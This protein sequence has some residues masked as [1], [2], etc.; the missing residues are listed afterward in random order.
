MAMPNVVSG[1]V[2]TG[3]SM[4]NDRGNERRPSGARQGHSG[5]AGSRQPSVYRAMHQP[6]LS[7]LASNGTEHAHVRTVAILGYN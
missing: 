7:V 5:S 4:G 6:P 3:S 1:E 2:R